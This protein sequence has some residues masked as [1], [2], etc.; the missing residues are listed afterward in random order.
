MDL[1]ELNHVLIPGS[2]SGRDRYRNMWFMR[3]LRFLGTPFMRLSREGRALL[4]M[5][6][7][8]ALFGGDLGGTQVHVLVLASTSLLVSAFLF[9]RA[10]RL[11][12]VTAGISLP[13]RVTLGDE[14]ALTISLRNDGDRTHRSIRV[15]PPLLPWDGAFTALPNDIEELP[16]GGH[17]TTTTRA[18][19]AARGEHHI[20]PFLAVALLPLGL[21]QGAPLRTSGARFVVVPKVA[22]VVSLT[23]PKNRRHQPGGI[24]R[25]SRTGDAT[26]L[27][28]V[29]PYRPGDPVR[30]L[31]ARSWARHGSPM[32]REY[33]EEYFTRIGIVVD[34]DASAASSAHLEGALSLA[35]G[36]VA[37]LCRGE[38]LVDVLVTGEHVEKLS[39]G[40]SLGSLDQALD[41]LAAVRPRPG[42]AAEA[43]LGRL[44][45][46]LER[47]S[48]VVLVALGWDDARAA[49]V[50][51]IRARGVETLVLVVGDRTSRTTHATTVA[52]DSITRGEALAL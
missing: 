36:V 3:R 41:V 25:A 2:K 24:A 32:V 42:F 47:L 31:H 19:F 48:S 51:A 44:S 28:G 17:L 33:Q 39:L 46:Y 16:R 4:V 1:A 23:T 22:R 38:A 52:L 8:A 9:T 35:A 20:D 21:S 37:S 5:V 34:T 29:R 18:R 43:M 12:G 27:L 50:A 40:R 49:F 30:D 15:V 7:M 45:P 6:G 14:I 13:R 10:Y 26:D 11:S